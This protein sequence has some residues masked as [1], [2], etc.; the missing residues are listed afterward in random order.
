MVAAAEQA[1]VTLM[2]GYPKR[3]DLAFTRFQ[4]EA[5]QLGGARLMRVTT[6]ESP[7]A[8]YVEHYPLLPREPLP[9]DV[10]QRFRDDNDARV[11]TAIGEAET[12]KNQPPI[13]RGDRASRP[14]PAAVMPAPPVSAAAIAE[15]AYSQPSGTGSHSGSSTDSPRAA[16]KNRSAFTRP[17]RSRA[18]ILTTISAISSR[19]GGA[20]K[21][22]HRANETWVDACTK[23][24]GSQAGIGTAAPRRAADSHA[25][26]GGQMSLL[27]AA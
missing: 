10:L 7:I 22:L 2:V 12:T 3:Y 6:F 26:G 1:G 25:F 19:G 20:V 8:A 24:V 5:A 21:I 13:V 15:A 18:G 9:P 23:P 11:R 27:G 17:A 4:K 16:A 14:Q